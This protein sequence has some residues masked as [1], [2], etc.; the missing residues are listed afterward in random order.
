MVGM[1]TGAHGRK[2]TFCVGSLKITNTEGNHKVGTQ[3]EAV[4][5]LVFSGLT[6]RALLGV[7]ASNAALPAPRGG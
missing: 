2:R 1:S 5:L 4:A 7:M 3:T 6:R